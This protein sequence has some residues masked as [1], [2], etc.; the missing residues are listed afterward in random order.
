MFTVL[1]VDDE[2]LLR[3][4]VCDRLQREGYQSFAAANGEE[5]QKLLETQTPDLV[6]LDMQMPGM[7]GLQFLKLLR[8]RPGMGKVP[9]IML[10]GKSDRDTVV[11]AAKLDVRDFMVK[12]TFSLSELLLTVRKYSGEPNAKPAPRP[13]QP[14]PR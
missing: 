8:D 4:L 13:E 11:A 6:L 12:S 5:A 14:P 10:T 9:V 2:V 3:D 7:S 1:M